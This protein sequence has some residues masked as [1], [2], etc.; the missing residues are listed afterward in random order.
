M[1]ATYQMGFYPEHSDHVPELHLPLP[2]S[3]LSN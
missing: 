2:A 3:I 1:S